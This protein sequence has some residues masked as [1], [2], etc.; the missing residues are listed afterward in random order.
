MA[1]APPVMISTRSIR[2]GLIEL[3]SSAALS[4]APATRRLPLTRTSVRFDPRLRR[5]TTARPP[6]FSPREPEAPLCWLCCMLPEKPIAGCWARARPMSNCA[7]FAP[8][9]SELTTPT[10]VGKSRTGRP[11]RDPVTTMSLAPSVAAPSSGA[12]AGASCACAVPATPVSPAKREIAR[13]DV[14]ILN[15]L[16]SAVA[17]PWIIFFLRPE[18]CQSRP[19]VG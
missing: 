12:G 10:G 15:L 14:E 5:S 4:V 18:P 9:V 3:R 7:L 2:L 16:L 13:S 6:L 1:D 11:I 8:S 19:F 17:G